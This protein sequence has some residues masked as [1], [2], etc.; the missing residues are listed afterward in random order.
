MKDQRLLNKLFSGGTKSESAWK[1]FLTLYSNLF[2]SIILKFTK[3]DDDIM[4]K[5]LFICSKLAA[6]N[7]HILKKFKP[8]Y[9]FK[10]PKLS[11]WLTVVV[12]NLCVD[13]FRAVNGRRRLPKAIKSFND[14]EICVFKLHFWFGYKDFEICRMFTCEED[15]DNNVM[16]TI[17]KIY[18]VLGKNGNGNLKN[19]KHVF[20]ELD[21]S[22]YISQQD[23]EL[24]ENISELLE[25]SINNLNERQKVI[26]KLRFWEGLSPLEISNLLG[27]TRRKVYE[28][29]SHSIKIIKKEFS[30]KLKA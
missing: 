9:S 28:T 15:T 2:I 21:E 18:D 4:A 16:Q 1:E 25:N 20:V 22:R 12:R 23:D 7:F 6:N 10:K 11:T 3:N 26:L 27:I 17:S 13:E 5:Y 29:L 14:F 24:P 19:I 30:D 8:K